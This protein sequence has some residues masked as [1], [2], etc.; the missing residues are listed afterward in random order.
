MQ[1][2]SSITAMITTAEHGY[3]FASGLPID[4]PA[5]EAVDDLMGRLDKA[6]L[7][8]PASTVPDLLAHVRALIEAVHLEAHLVGPWTRGLA[9]VCEVGLRRLAEDV[10]PCVASLNS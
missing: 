10:A 9:D 1:M 4:D 7:T 2:S 8:T 6:I 5:T 3:R